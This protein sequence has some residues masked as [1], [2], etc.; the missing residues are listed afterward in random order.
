MVEV[1]VVKLAIPW[2]PKREPGVDVPIPTLPLLLK[3]S[4]GVV[5]PYASVV[6]PIYRLPPIDENS[7]CLRFTPAPLSVSTNCLPVVVAI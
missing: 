6:V 2:I 5:V 1:P 7:Q 4:A 3:V